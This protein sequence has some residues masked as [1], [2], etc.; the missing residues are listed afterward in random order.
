MPEDVDLYRSADSFVSNN[1]LF[2][3]NTRR[4][5]RP[6]REVAEFAALRQRVQGIEVS[7]AIAESSG[8]KVS[9]PEPLLLVSP[10]Y[11]YHK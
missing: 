1:E 3:E 9:S 2:E 8:V 5:S 6:S 10:Q 4:V 11:Q 7:E